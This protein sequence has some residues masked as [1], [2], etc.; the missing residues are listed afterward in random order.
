MLCCV[1]GVAQLCEL[2]TSD[3]HPASNAGKQLCEL[4]T[5]DTHPASNSG[6]LL[7]WRDAVIWIKY[8]RT[9]CTMIG[10][11]LGSGLQRKILCI[12]YMSFTCPVY[13]EFQDQNLQRRARVHDM[14]Y[15]ICNGRRKV[16]CIECYTRKYVHIRRDAR[17]N[18][19]SKDM[20]NNSYT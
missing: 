10:R 13:L 20:H 9:Q 3:A 15:S 6:M 8:F 19:Y 12:T 17:P 1:P 2:R 11:W 18:H 7:A 16:F 5:S 4:C 14:F